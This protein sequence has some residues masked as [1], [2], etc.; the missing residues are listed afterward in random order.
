MR[1]VLA[2]DDSGLATTRAVFIQN[3]LPGSTVETIPTESDLLRRIADWAQG[4]EAAPDALVLDGRLL[5]SENDPISPG[6]PQL[7]AGRRAI[8]AVRSTD[9]LKHIPIVAYS[10]DAR[11]F[12]G[13]TLDGHTQLI[14]KEQVPEG[15]VGALRSLLSASGIR[16]PQAK[17]GHHHTEKVILRVAALIGAV[18]VIAGAFGWIGD[19][20]RWAFGAEER[21]YSYVT[22]SPTATQQYALP[23]PGAVAHGR[24]YL[25]LG[26]EVEVRC[27][28]DAHGERWLLVMDRGWLRGQDVTAA[29]TEKIGPARLPRCAGQ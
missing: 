12:E 13:L 28:L 21:T 10:V 5:W 7:E 4:N 6:K 23:E 16:I 27:A 14:G 25:P 11:A 1:I 22:I 15:L 3:G 20:W 9:R 26:T 19:V 18:T 2:E 24:G 8:E 29:A 17:G